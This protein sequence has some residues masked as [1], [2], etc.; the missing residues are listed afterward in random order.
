MPGAWG[1]RQKNA[2]SNQIVRK[3]WVCFSLHLSV[4]SEGLQGSPNQKNGDSHWNLLDSW[5]GVVKSNEEYL[6]E[7]T[8]SLSTMDCLVHTIGNEGFQTNKA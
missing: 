3:K 8:T 7:T 4:E 5:E 1:P 2:W 6:F